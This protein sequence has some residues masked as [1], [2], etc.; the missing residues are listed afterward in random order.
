MNSFPQSVY[1]FS[2]STV[3]KRENSF[4]DIKSQ[5]S[6]G[7]GFDRKESNGRTDVDIEPITPRKR[8]S[9]SQMSSILDRRHLEDVTNHQQE[10]MQ[11]MP[12]PQNILNREPNK[13][14][15]IDDALT[16]L[17]SV[18]FDFDKKF[19]CTDMNFVAQIKQRLDYKHILK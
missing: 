11:Q 13:T 10:I 9:D 7:S 16:K 14:L 5:S 12:S 3:N 6:Y 4:Y 18:S 15:I 1:L 19:Q 8:V 17:D 2:V